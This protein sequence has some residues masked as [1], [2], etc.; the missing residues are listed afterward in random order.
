MILG[1]HSASH[2]M[3]AGTSRRRRAVRPV[4]VVSAAGDPKSSFEENRFWIRERQAQK[5][6]PRRRKK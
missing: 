2:E 4:R 5:R 3:Y 1:G 6:K